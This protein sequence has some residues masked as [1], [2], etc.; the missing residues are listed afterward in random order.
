MK[1]LFIYYSLTGNGDI[2]SDYLKEKNIEIRKVITREPLPKG[3]IM[4]ILAGGFLAGINHCDKLDNFNCDIREYDDII[5]GTPIWN[6]RPSCPINTVLKSIDLTNKNITFILY[7]GSGN[8][9]K[10]EEYINKNYSSAK[11]INIKEPKKN[12]ELLV[13]LLGDI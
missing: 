13:T 6:G 3:K 8:A 7:S 9:P 1:K 11:I 10:T 12:K 4:R 2:I 5:I